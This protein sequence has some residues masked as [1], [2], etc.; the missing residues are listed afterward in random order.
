MT[1][2]AQ[3][4]LWGTQFPLNMGHTDMFF[5]PINIQFKRKQAVASGQAVMLTAATASIHTTQFEIFLHV[6]SSVFV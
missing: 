2:K 1:S 3:L 6:E 5:I 4:S